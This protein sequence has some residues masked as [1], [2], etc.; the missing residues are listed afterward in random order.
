MERHRAGEWDARDAQALTRASRG[1]AMPARS[2]FLHG[3]SSRMIS[4]RTSPRASPYSAFTM[5][6]AACISTAESGEVAWVTLGAVGDGSIS[7]TWGSTEGA[8]SFGMAW[9]PDRA[10]RVGQR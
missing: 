7:D 1:T 5:S 9:S 6:T 2:F 4:K 10:H 8:V 3:S